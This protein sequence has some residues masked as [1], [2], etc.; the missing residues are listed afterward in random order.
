[1]SDPL[2]PFGP[3]GIPSGR[4]LVKQYPFGRCDI[5]SG[6]SSV[7]SIIRSDDEN[8]PFGPSSV[9]RSFELFQLASV[10][11][12]QQQVWTTLSVQPTMGFLYKTQIWEDRCNRS[13]AR[14]TYMEIACI[15]STVQTTITL[16]RTREALI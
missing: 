13:D 9:S 8:F 11:T 5:P 12:F 10:Q 7:Q 3:H 4:S 6:R 1:L 2:H 15:K 14:A 16:V